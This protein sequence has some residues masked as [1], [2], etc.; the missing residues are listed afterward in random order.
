[1]L[2]GVPAVSMGSMAESSPRIIHFAMHAI[3]AFLFHVRVCG[4]ELK[5]NDLAIIGL[6]RILSCGIDYGRKRLN[7]FTFSIL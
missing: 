7:Y 5:K 1:M 2:S 3:L 4:F 6:I